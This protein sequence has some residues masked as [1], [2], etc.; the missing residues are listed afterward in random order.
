[1]HGQVI[2]L[3]LKWG[4]LISWHFWCFD[5]SGAH[6]TNA[7]N[8]GFALTSGDEGTS[9]EDWVVNTSI[10]SHMN[11]LFSILIWNINLKIKG[12]NDKAVSWDHITC[13]EKDDV[14]ND[15][16]P[17]TD[18]LGSTEFTSND[19]NLLFHNVVR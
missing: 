6:F 16:V 14:T 11:N 10:K 13:V 8:N 18:A 2:K 12:V 17:N 3:I 7:A 9:V 19:W 15:N 4:V 1:M 5:T